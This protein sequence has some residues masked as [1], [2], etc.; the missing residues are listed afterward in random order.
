MLSMG[1][2]YLTI[3]LASTLQKKKKAH[4]Q[5]PGPGIDLNACIVSYS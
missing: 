5:V 2:L 1:E 4:S 3:V